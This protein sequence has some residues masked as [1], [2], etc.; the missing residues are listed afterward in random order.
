MSK[1]KSDDL[2]NSGFIMSV[3]RNVPEF[4]VFSSSLPILPNDIW[5]IILDT[6]IDSENGRWC[7]A[8]SGCCINLANVCKGWKN[9]VHLAIEKRINMAK[10]DDKILIQILAH[11]FSHH[12]ASFRYVSITL[13]VLEA[14]DNWSSTM[15]IYQTIENMIVL[16]PTLYI[17]NSIKEIS[18]YDPAIWTLEDLVNDPDD[19]DEFRISSKNPPSTD[20]FMY[21]VFE[22]LLS[23]DSEFIFEKDKEWEK[24]E[25]F[26]NRLLAKKC[27]LRVIQTMNKGSQ[28]PH[29]LRRNSKDLLTKARKNLHLL[30][31]KIIC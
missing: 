14:S 24:D 21:R 2:S 15:A 6:L 13:P 28:F 10:T 26:L 31:S 8:G 7:V 23:M 5:F 18:S 29:N 4:K 11:Q 12:L 20:D 3:S 25:Y 17:K 16:S 27:F 1:R 19:P 30:N 22:K 9:L